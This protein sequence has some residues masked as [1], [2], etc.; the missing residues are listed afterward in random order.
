MTIYPRSFVFPLHVPSP[1]SLSA[2]AESGTAIYKTPSAVVPLCCVK[3]HV[4]MSHTDV[5]TP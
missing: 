1:R 5:P 3:Y 4:I 2:G